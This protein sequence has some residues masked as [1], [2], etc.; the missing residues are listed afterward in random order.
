ARRGELNHA[1]VCPMASDSAGG[2]RKAR[3]T[4]PAR[5]YVS[6]VRR[7]ILNACLANAYAANSSRRLERVFVWRARCVWGEGRAVGL[8][9]SLAERLEWS[10][11]DMR[12]NER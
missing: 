11:R 10:R 7:A 6:S 9:A 8:Q 4:G 1:G 2:A 3:V 5:R 12:S